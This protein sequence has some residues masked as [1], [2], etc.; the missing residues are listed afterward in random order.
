ERAAIRPAR[1]D[2]VAQMLTFQ[3]LHAALD[4]WITAYN[5][6]FPHS[7]LDYRTP[8]QYEDQH[9]GQPITAAH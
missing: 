6:D 8:Q 7:A 4:R 5:T 3:Q 1:L 9:A 2:G